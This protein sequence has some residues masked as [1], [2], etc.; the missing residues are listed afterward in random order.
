MSSDH[1][2]AAA[3]GRPDENIAQSPAANGLQ[4][5]DMRLDDRITI[6]ARG[7]DVSL[8]LAGDPHERH[9]TGTELASLIEDTYWKD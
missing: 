9:V 5:G 1:K 4:N 2:R 7:D 6:R 3:K 8:L